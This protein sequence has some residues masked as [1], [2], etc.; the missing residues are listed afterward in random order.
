MSMSIL[1]KSLKL[2]D[3]R[4]HDPAD[5]IFE[6]DEIKKVSA[7]TITSDQLEE[8]DCSGWLASKGWI[9]LRCFAGEPGLEHRETLES[10]GDTLK[11]SGFVEAVLL[12]NT[13]PAIQSKNEVEFIKSKIR[14]FF[15][16]I[17]LQGAITKDT[18]GEDFTDIL[19][20]HHHGVRIFGEGTVPLSNSD[21]MMKALQY[22]QKFNGI[23][24]DHSYDPLLAMFGQMHEGLTSTQIGLKGIPAMAEEVAVKRNIDIL[25]YTGGSLHFQT[26]STAGV[27]EA[28]RQA[29]EEGLQVTADVSLYQLLFSDQDLIDFDTNLKVI[30]PYR[31]N[32]DREALIEGLTDGT[33]DA[34]V[35]NHQPLEVDGKQMELDLATYG[36]LGLPTFLHGL[37]QLEK[38][39]GWPMLIS[40]I[41]KGPS[42]VLQRAETGFDTLTI[43]D[44]RE[45]W[46]FDRYSNPSLS[47]N[48][49]WFNGRLNGRIKFLIN[50][51]KLERING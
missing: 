33:I 44:P 45:E 27:V 37:I 48:S 38:E 36:I 7:Q 18:L 5:Y 9:D 31:G 14:N 8:I 6:G 2:I 50:K 30:R 32:E 41:T 34:I 25:K 26:V 29:K 46:R 28:I 13:V 23:L 3:D 16:T 49:P 24:F 20:M 21:R 17:H 19:D 15:T 12:P 35:S 51:G 43:F 11:K 40:K 22:L 47:E 42:K 4:V 39:L 1:F 10:L